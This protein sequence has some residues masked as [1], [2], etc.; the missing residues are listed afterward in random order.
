[1]AGDAPD[2]PSDPPVTGDDARTQNPIDDPGRGNTGGGG[3][4]G[5]G[6]SPDGPVNPSGDRL[7]AT[8]DDPPSTPAIVIPAASAR[9]VLDQQLRLFPD[10]VGAVPPDAVLR[11]ITDTAS[12]IWDMRALSAAD[13]AHAAFVLGTV[14]DSRRNWQ[15]CASWLDSAVAL[16]PTLRGYALLRTR[17]LEQI[18]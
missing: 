1:L 4:P 15:H 12:A 11:A 13:R 18:R 14:Y 6:G 17:C 3:R 5:G 16:N 2:S 8:A 9:A 10:E 7:P